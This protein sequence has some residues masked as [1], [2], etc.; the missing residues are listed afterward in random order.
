MRKQSGF[1]LLEIAI[2]LVII[3]LLMVGVF[4]GQDLINSAKVKTFANDF[5]NIPLLI[6]GY[7][8]KYRAI[9]GD[10]SKAGPHLGGTPPPGNGNGL[11][12]G[13]WYPTKFT[14]SAI[15]WQHVR[16]AK[17]ASGPIVPGVVTETTDVPPDFLPR[18]T[19]GGIIGI[20]SN[21]TSKYITGLR[22]TYL[23]CSA[24][25][26]G[27]F[28]KQLDIAMDDGCPNT[29][30]MMAVVGTPSGTDNSAVALAASGAICT[31]ATVL[32]EDTA[33]TV[34]MGF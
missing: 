26:L 28:V 24:G 22:G 17:L 18:N 20:Q 5:R 19:D 10:D 6:Y 7:Q 15:F 8:D 12:D 1:T 32:D 21:L 4:K 25:L 29:G 14:E 23:I 30:A 33:Y 2:V 27:R 9:P 3:G 13:T 16:L 34:C 31:G 11:I